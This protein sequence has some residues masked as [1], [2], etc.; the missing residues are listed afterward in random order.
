M[1]FESRLKKRE[2]GDIS[3]IRGKGFAESRSSK[4]PF[5]PWWLAGGNGQIISSVIGDCELC[6]VRIPN[7]LSFLRLVFKKN[8]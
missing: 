1:S 5:A 6:D 3:Y 2:G 4:K 7:F 8:C